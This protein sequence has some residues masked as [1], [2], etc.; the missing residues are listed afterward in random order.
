MDVGKDSRYNRLFENLEYRKNKLIEDTRR[1]PAS[2][3]E[4]QALPVD[5]RMAV[6][7]SALRQYGEHHSFSASY[8]RVVSIEPEER[9]GLTLGASVTYKVKSDW[10]SGKRPEGIEVSVWARDPAAQVASHDEV[11]LGELRHG[12]YRDEEGEPQNGWHLVTDRDGSTATLNSSRAVDALEF[13]DLAVTGIIDGEL[14]AER[15]RLGGQAISGA[16][17][18]TDTEA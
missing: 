1:F 8:A 12:A 17:Q 2:A 18:P 14:A 9:P 4:Y 6:A 3:E 11:L 10:G 16:N 5:E 13:V 15:K 7:I